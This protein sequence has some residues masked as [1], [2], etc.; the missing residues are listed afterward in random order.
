MVKCHFLY[1]S[2]SNK[3]LLLKKKNVFISLIIMTRI[4]C[5]PILTGVSLLHTLLTVFPINWPSNW[6]TVMNI[7]ISSWKRAK[8]KH[9]TLLYHLLHNKWQK[10]VCLIIW[11]ETNYYYC[12]RIQKNIAF[13][14]KKRTESVSCDKVT[15]R[16]GQ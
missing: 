2:Y 7:T 6:E 5:N 11:S 15:Y 9:N 13:C 10:M 4:Y 1:K 3:F 16:W 8:K 14:I 12:N